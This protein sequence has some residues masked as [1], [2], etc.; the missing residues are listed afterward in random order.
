MPSY[1]DPFKSSI[2]SYE[3]LIYHAD[4]DQTPQH[5]VSAQD[6]HC[7]LTTFSIK[8]N[9]SENIPSSDP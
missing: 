9:K 4:Q 7:L 3:T 1:C 5:E 6:L 2:V 8:L